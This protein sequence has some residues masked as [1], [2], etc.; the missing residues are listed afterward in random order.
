MSAFRLIRR[1]RRTLRRLYGGPLGTYIDRIAAWYDEQGYE[2]GYAVASLKSVDCFGR[3]LDRRRVNLRDVDE[4]LI[5]RYVLQRPARSHSGTRVALH[6][7]L[8]VLREGGASAPKMVMRGPA[9]ILEDDFKQYLMSECGLAART[10]EHYTDA[11]HIFLAALYGQGRREPSQWT[12]A[13][14]LTFVRQHAEA[15]RPAHMQRL[16]TGLR[17]FLRYLRLR[18]KVQLDLVS[19]IPRIA[20]W[21]LATLPKSLSRAQVESV[22]AHCDHHT[23]IGRRNFA[24][25]MLLA[26]LGLRAHEVRCLTLDDI[27]WRNGRVTIHGK[28]REV[29]QM[30]LPVEVGKALAA[31]LANGRPP[32]TDRAVFVR[33]TPPY[34]Q[35]AAGGA[36]TT[37]AANAIRAADVDA[38]SKGAHVFRHT[39]ATQML[40]EGASLREIG[41]LLRHRH[42]DTTRIYAKVD[43]TRLRT[44]ALP[45]PGGAS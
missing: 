34:T 30:P 11:A 21:R 12:V 26:R 19:S 42:E 8:V 37:I 25:L 10:I 2:R 20:H 6:R 4:Q 40:R 29:E 23:A 45:W 38:P 15:R 44:L 1:G 39:L 16:C 13:D 41:Q 27:D 28:G 24:V 17:S 5:D 7:L 32:S 14:L 3:W 18:G 22:L 31:Y 43:L 35:F 9:Q 36:I 33:S